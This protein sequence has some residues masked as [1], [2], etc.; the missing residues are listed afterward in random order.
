MSKPSATGASARAER[1]SS[2][3]H[4]RSDAVARARQ[5]GVTAASRELFMSPHTLSNWVHFDNLA[6]GQKPSERQI[7]SPEIRASAL[8][9][10][11]FM[12]VPEVARKIGVSVV[13]LYKWRK[14][15]VDSRS[16]AKRSVSGYGPEFREF[17]VL[18]SEDVGP[19]KAARVLE[20][21]RGTLSR[22]YR[23]HRL[24]NGQAKEY[25]RYPDGEREA[26]L[27]LI[28]SGQTVARVALSRGIAESTLRNWQLAARGGVAPRPSPTKYP[29][30]FVRDVLIKAETEGVHE[31]AEKF[32]VS[33]RRIRTWSKSRGISLPRQKGRQVNADKELRW[34]LKFDGM[35]EWR[36]LGVSWIGEQEESVSQK[37]Q[38]LR[39]FFFQYIIKLN[40]PRDPER[41]LLR[42]AKYPV[43]CGSGVPDTR[44]GRVISNYVHEFLQV[45][46]YEHFGTEDVYGAPVVRPGFFNP[47]TPLG[48]GDLPA[49]TQSVHPTLP[50]GF[51]DEMSRIVAEGPHFSDWKWAQGELGVDEGEQGTIATDWFPVPPTLIDHRDP[52]CVWRE[53]LRGAQAGGVVLEMWSPVRWV[54]QLLKYVTPFRN[55]QLRMLDSGEADTWCYCGNGFG[56]GK[57]RRNES[58]LAR[59]SDIRPHA[60]GV[61]RRPKNEPL[62]G[63]QRTAG[64]YFF[65]NTN[66]SADRRKSGTQKGYVV[67]WPSDQPIHRNPYYWLSKLRD[68]QGKYNPIDRAA[69]WTELEE[70][71]HLP[72][73]SFSQL[74]QYPPTCFLLRLPEAVEGE[75]HLPLPNGLLDY[76]HYA[77]LAELQRRCASTG[78]TNDDGSPLEFVYSAPKRKTMFPLHAMRTSLASALVH[79][80]GMGI[81]ELQQLLG[82]GSRYMSEYYAKV[83]PLRVM[84]ALHECLSALAR[85]AGASIVRFLRQAEFD[86][87]EAE[88][89]FNSGAAL[90][91][92]VP[93]SCPDRNPAGWMQLHLGLCMVGGNAY[94]V[95]GITAVGGCFNGG[96]NVGTDS[97][98]KHSQVEGGTRNCVRCRWLASSPEYL[99]ALHNHL[100]VCL[101]HLHTSKEDWAQREQEAEE[102]RNIRADCEASAVPFLDADRLTQHVR[103]VDAALLRLT[104]QAKNVAATLRLI[105]RCLAILELQ[106]DAPGSQ[107]LVAVGTPRDLEIAFKAT[108]SELLQVSG[109]CEA[110]ELY[111][112][113]DPGKAVL[114]QGQ[115]LDS[116][117]KR[118]GALPV[119]VSLSEADQLK[120]GNA[121]LRSLASACNPADP[122][123]GR[124]QVISL[125]DAEEHLSKHLGIDLRVACET[126]ITPITNGKLAELKL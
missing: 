39:A 82:H 120:F 97:R 125:I 83:H 9:F 76:T 34:L 21:P 75:R 50:Y 114:R 41:L 112:D 106:S 11:E 123:Q 118:E 87:L 81:P 90:A 45:V 99:L 74:S 111:P 10:M 20:F 44:H 119:F 6:R 109:V 101:Y 126:L 57:W 100:N 48:F 46:L 2:V 64:V 43:F 12:A 96:P 121:L 61:F 92:A 13:T 62:S 25:V 91:A 4:Q 73:K 89:A 68:W 56:E 63:G 58:L 86:R 88:L 5:V 52:D 19:E 35:G 116:A 104:E 33:V 38:A 94:P 107:A 29:E 115:L 66:K 18:L 27:A 54:T 22:W 26:A 69:A 8:Q 77:V 47:L 72:P 31:A 3:Q 15:E 93:R 84:T 37:L 71:R 32:E 14:Q 1:V 98:P 80:G 40:L 16:I 51:L 95:P 108:N 24:L 70:G 49:H 65:C 23:E 124:T 78:R 53:R 42:A 105:R 85:E 30:S 36:Q 55:H 117:L 67:P 102:M 122:R 60:Q 110:T 79:D 7:W 59:G 103:L 17:A 113:L 28:A